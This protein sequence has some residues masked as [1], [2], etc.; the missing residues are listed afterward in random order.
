MRL[1]SVA[2][3]H[4]RASG[5]GMVFPPD[6]GI[7]RGTTLAEQVYEILSGRLLMGAWAPDT[8][9]SVRGLAEDL[10]V[11]ITPVR[12]AM[13]RLANEGAL[14]NIDGRGFRTV[15][16]DRDQYEE[17][18]RL[19]LAIEPMAAALA[20]ERMTGAAVDALEQQN[21]RLGSAIEEGDL[22]RA[23]QIDTSF[24]M[25][26][27]EQ[28]GQPLV[29]SMIGSLLLRAGPT[30]TRLSGDYRRS[31]RGV[32]HHRSIVEALRKRDGPAAS[33]ELAADLRDGSNVILAEL[34]S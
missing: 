30:R 28:A 7:H 14:D 22:A 33:A 23:L 2:N 29:L 10:S 24:H 34:T 5:D 17:I 6:D 13:N 1:V 16:L 12:D 4:D 26:L 27:Y 20:T 3:A 25:M 18:V 8:R 31:F 9:L 32:L 19:R 11:S 15:R 21:E